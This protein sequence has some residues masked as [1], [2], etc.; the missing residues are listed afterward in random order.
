MTKKMINFVWSFSFW[1][2]GQKMQQNRYVSV[3]VWNGQ[4]ETTTDVTLHL[5]SSSSKYKFLETLTWCC[6]LLLVLPLSVNSY[7]LVTHGRGSSVHI[8]N[9]HT[10]A[11]ACDV[12]L[13]RFR[14][15]AKAFVRLDSALRQLLCTRIWIAVFY[16]SVRLYVVVSWIRQKHEQCHTSDKRWRKNMP[17]WIETKTRE[18]EEEVGSSK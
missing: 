18:E 3:S 6:W 10:R 4:H 15:E 9:A 12:Q 7:Q 17:K 1:S 8:Q 14:F 2:S 5:L 16:S 11:H 13:E